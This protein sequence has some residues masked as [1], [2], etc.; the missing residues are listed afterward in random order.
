MYI[1]LPTFY[2]APLVL[3]FGLTQH[4]GLAEDVLDHRLNTRTVYMNPVFRFLYW[5]M[6]YHIEHHMFPTVPYHA[7]PR[8]HELVK[9]DMP[10]PY[11]STIAAY[12][13]IIPTVLRQLREPGWHIVRQLPPGARRPIA[14]PAV[15]AE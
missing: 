6:N 1:L 2:G 8:L 7:L 9:A 11:P 12:R 15:A 14:A 10:V 5:N 3:F 13:E 4:A